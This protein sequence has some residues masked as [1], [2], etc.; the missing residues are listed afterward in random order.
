MN[1]ISY[2]FLFFIFVPQLASAQAF[3]VQQGDQISKY[4]GKPTR[5]PNQYEIKAPQPHNEFESYLV[6]STPLTGICKIT[7]IGKSHVSDD[8]GNEIKTIFLSFKTVLA[9]KY[10]NSKNF[11]FLKSGSIWTEPREYGWSLYK[12]ERTL[13]SFWDDTEGSVNLN[14]IQGIML[15]ATAISPSVT[16]LTLTY[17]FRNIDKCTEISASGNNA[18][19]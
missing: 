14:R 16:Y 2:L 8:Y 13:T 12:K 10:G 19:L 17:E 11:D 6:T 5:Q 3:G 15:N 4:G 9:N 1:Y 7:G 18:G